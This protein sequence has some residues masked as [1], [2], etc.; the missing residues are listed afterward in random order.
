MK[1]YKKIAPTKGKV[2][3]ELQFEKLNAR[4]NLIKLFGVN[5][6]TLVFKPLACIINIR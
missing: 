1:V 4:V 5:L 2:K 3:V 6:L